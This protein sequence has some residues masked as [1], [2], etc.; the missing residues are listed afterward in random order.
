MA[1]ERPEVNLK[2]TTWMERVPVQSARNRRIRDWCRGANAELYYFV[3][4][5]YYTLHRSETR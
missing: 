3:I 1:N 5:I 4:T 2:S